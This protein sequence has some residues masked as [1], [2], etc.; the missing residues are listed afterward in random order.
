MTSRHSLF[1]FLVLIQFCSFSYCSEN[2]DTE[3]WR[4]VEINS[5]LT[6]YQ[7]LRK[8]KNGLTQCATNDRDTCYFTESL[9]KCLE[10]KDLNGV[11]T[12]GRKHKEIFGFTGFD[13]PLH[14]CNSD[15]KTGFLT[16]IS[17]HSAIETSEI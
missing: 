14:W 7:V 9:S 13:R 16:E 4:C 12:C 15:I 2:G 1:Y 5:N 3:K 6:T 10:F 17:N 11:I 8:N